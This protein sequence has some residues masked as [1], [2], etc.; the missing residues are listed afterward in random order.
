MAKYYLNGLLVFA[1]LLLAACGGD[2]GSEPVVSEPGEALAEFTDQEVT[3]EPCDLTLFP[4]DFREPLGTLG[5]R[6]ECAT[7]KT[8]LDWSDP[9]LDEINLGVLRVR[10]GVEAERK[11]AIFINPGGPGGDGLVYG[12][13]FGLYFVPGDAPPSSPGVAASGLLAQ[14]S[15]QYDVIGF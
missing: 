5:E 4:E 12:A 2:A 15:D 10:A 11:G 14:L 13:A 3:W 8:P 6:L 1:L 9:A 7:L